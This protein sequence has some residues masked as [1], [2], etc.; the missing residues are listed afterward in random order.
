MNPNW[1]G[2]D[3]ISPVGEIGKGRW[4]LPGQ[5]RAGLRMLHRLNRYGLVLRAPCSRPLTTHTD[6]GI[7]NQAGVAQCL[8]NQA[9]VGLL[10]LQRDDIVF[11]AYAD[12]FDERQVHS[13]QSISKMLVNLIAARCVNHGLVDLERAVIDYLP[14]IG[15][16]YASASVQ[17]LLD[18]N[19][20]NSFIEDY[21]DPD[22]CVGK[23]ECAH[24][25]RIDPDNPRQS[26]R[27]YLVSIGGAAQTS[28][29]GEVQYKTANTDIVAWICEQAARQTLRNSLL[30]LVEQA[31]MENAVYVST[32]REGIP[33]LGGGLHM[34]LRDLAR[35][36]RLFCFD[37][38]NNASQLCLVRQALASPAAGTRY[39]DGIFYRNFLET[40][41][42]FVGHL[43]YGGQ[44]LYVEPAQAI[45]I[46][47]FNAID[48]EDGID[49]E[50]IIRLRSICS[51]IARIL[52]DK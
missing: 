48:D 40:D 22:A 31:G 34:T 29:Q 20:V 9:F 45:V 21:A 35:L 41:G 26:I 5:R 51:A 37:N 32:D 36:G 33:F 12:D 52:A 47:A 3:G 14:S 17:Q 7:G 25:W 30:D 27:D 2:A 39:S 8:D 1:P 13:V 11:E 50:F 24:G 15:S 10:V 49:Y 38:E 18:M 28:E 6:A 46:A 4:D 42:R 23:L 19:V 43:G 16:G 44:Y